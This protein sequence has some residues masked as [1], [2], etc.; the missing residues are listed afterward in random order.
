M[1]RFCA[2]C[3]VKLGLDARFCE[4]CCA[5]VLHAPSATEPAMPRGT[6]GHL[7]HPPLNLKI[8]NAIGRD[9]N[10]FSTIRL[11]D[12]D[13]F[14]L[15]LGFGHTHVHRHRLMPEVCVPSTTYN[16]TEHALSKM[17]I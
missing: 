3:R 4:L 8:I 5:R 17:R 9:G 6:A 1:A 2:Q 11:A 10:T 16:E 12:R 15:S 13:H 14:E 7:C